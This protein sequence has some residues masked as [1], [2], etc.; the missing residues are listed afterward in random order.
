MRALLGA[1]RHDSGLIFVAGALALLSV[2]VLSGH[3]VKVLAP[4]TAI[5]GLAAA[6]RRAVIGWHRLIALI[7]LVVMFVPIGRYKL[8]GSL[9]STSSS[10]A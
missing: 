7:V 5:V 1:S 10:I 2:G 4:L 6:S 8:P 9:P 3:G